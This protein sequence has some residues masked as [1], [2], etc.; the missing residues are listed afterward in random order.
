MK[1]FDVTFRYQSRSSE[2]VQ[3]TRRVDATNL[4]GATARATREFMKGLDRK[5]RF[6]V[7]KSGLDIRVVVSLGEKSETESQKD[8]PEQPIVT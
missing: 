8:P 3:T 1:T 7:N 6:D 4:S 5:Q 2:T